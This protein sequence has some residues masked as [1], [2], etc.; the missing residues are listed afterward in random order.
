MMLNRWKKVALFSL[1]GIVIAVL[2]AAGLEVYGALWSNPQWTFISRDAPKMETYGVGTR[3]DIRTGRFSPNEGLVHFPLETDL[4]QVDLRGTLWLHSDLPKT[5]TYALVALVDYIQAPVVVSETSR[6]AHI[7]QVKPHSRAKVD[8]AL[9]IPSQEGRHKLALL[10]FQAPETHR[11]DDKFRF[12]TDGMCFYQVLDVV[13]GDDE[14]FPTVV[15]QQAPETKS[16]VSQVEFSGILINRDAHNNRTAWLTETVHSQQ[17]LTYY[18][19]LGNDGRSRVPYALIAF[20][21]WQQIPVA[22]EGSEAFSGFIEEGG[23]LTL[24]AEVR[25]PSEGSAHELQVIYVP[26]PNGPIDHVIPS[27]RVGLVQTP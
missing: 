9:T 14:I 22:G 8:F 4:K 5:E 7:V 10:I 13:I 25:I 26:D 23:R 17:T 3:V 15:Y 16:N 24:P 6:S 27:L 2:V 19:H 1:L 18:V 11:L 21:D 20:L 12:L